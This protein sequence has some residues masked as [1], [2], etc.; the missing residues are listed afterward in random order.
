MPDP[1]EL[2]YH[3][4]WTSW[5]F[6]ARIVSGRSQHARDA[7]HDRMTQAVR[8]ATAGFWPVNTR[9]SVQ[10]GP[11]WQ[12]KSASLLIATGGRYRYQ[13]ASDQ[14]DEEG[15]ALIVCDGHSFAKIYEE[16]A[17]ADRYPADPGETPFGDLVNPAW[18]V[19]GFR[20]AGQGTTEYAGRAAI[21]VTATPRLPSTLWHYLEA[22]C[23][24]IELLADAE[25]GLV[26]RLEAILDGEPASVT[27]LRDLV[28]DPEAAGDPAS[29]R[30][31]PGVGITD[32]DYCPPLN[33]GHADGEDITA[34]WAAR[35][36]SRAAVQIAARYLARPQPPRI[37]LADTEPAIPSAPIE[38]GDRQPIS[39]QAL[40]LLAQDGKPPLNLRARAHSWIAAA[41]ARPAATAGIDQRYDEGRLLTE[42]FGIEPRPWFK[43]KDAHRVATL[44]VALP[45]RYRVDYLVDER[46]RLPVTVACNDSALLKI[47]YNRV[48]ASPPQPLPAEFVRLLDPAWLL[49]RWQLSEAGEQQV[50]GRSALCVVAEPPI[51]PAPGKAL[52]SS[53]K[54][55]PSARLVVLVDTELGVVLRS[56]A[57]VNDE[58]A[59]R[60]ELR[61]LT[62]LDT[63]EPTDFDR[64]IAPDLPLL[65]SDGAP[66]NDLDLPPAARAVRDVG[67]ELLSGAESALGWLSRLISDQTRQR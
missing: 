38:V 39:D 10:A 54:A 28:F 53:H 7:L 46:E 43:A 44:R 45:G 20:L 14:D 6:S 56:V 33:A 13:Q 24:R 60:S 66:I 34:A 58:P 63:A 35:A 27:E 59:A 61:D 42:F 25:L 15:T 57:Y 12:E 32:H 22:A 8:R 50:D 37:S 30:P 48:V 52:S 2:L 19:S 40:H 47:Y 41:Q 18:L 31:P 16:D 64:S 26:F 11:D 49:R 1:L 65:D 21:K 17:E 36:A 5:S 55:P 51:A 67:A 23:D 4:D 29:F 9:G 3:A 62:L